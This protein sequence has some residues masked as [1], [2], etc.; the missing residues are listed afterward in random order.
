M[1]SSARFASI[2]RQIL[3]RYNDE[4]SPMNK[5][6]LEK[7]NRFV[8]KMPCYLE[9][10]V[11][12]IL[13]V[14]VAYSCIQLVLHV[15]DFSGLEFNAYIDD[16][17]VTAFDA[18]IVIEFVRMLVKHSMNTILEV[19]IFALARSLVVG[20]EDAVKILIRILCIAVLLACRKFL[21]HDFDFKEED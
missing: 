18:I 10:I 2:L 14:G 12:A 4:R 5:T 3:K 16:I 9:R 6:G 21:F 20:H 11:A 7:F 13:L 19:L 15:V 17:L 1:I 8:N